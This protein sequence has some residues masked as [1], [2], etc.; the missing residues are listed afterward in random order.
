MSISL[1]IAFE[2]FSLPEGWTGSPQEFCDL[3]VE[4]LSAQAELSTGSANGT[5]FVEGL[6]GGSTPT[7]DIGLWITPTD[8]N[9]FVNGAYQSVTDVPVGCIIPGFLTAPPANYL[10]C[11]GGVYASADY[12]LL[13]AVLGNASNNGVGIATPGG[14]TPGTGSFAVP[15]LRSRIP[16]GANTGVNNNSQAAN[17]GNN[18][19]GNAATNI[20]GSLA[21]Y[22]LGQYGGLDT[23][24]VANSYS[25]LPS[26]LAFVAGTTI[27][28]GFPKY[29]SIDQPFIV[30]NWYVRY[31]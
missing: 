17:S 2:Q 26:H 6:I 20:A 16:V 9:L 7:Q 21:P 30:V 18:N 28:G 10:L 13:A 8:L 12:P 22:S 11:D 25:G 4:N 1:D 19:D 24:Y 5:N 3:I 27:T 29:A 23:L 14:V 31:R 15:D